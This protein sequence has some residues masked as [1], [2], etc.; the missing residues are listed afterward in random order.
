MDRVG[1]STCRAYGVAKAC[2]SPKRKG[3]WHRIDL[4][5]TP[6]RRLITV[7]VQLSMMQPAERDRK[8]VADLAP[9]RSGLGKAQVVWLGRGATAHQAGLLRHEPT[10]LLIAKANGLRDEGRRADAE[11]REAGG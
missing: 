3:D 10:V 6:P 7:P 8:L 1:A 9:E 4:E 2:A 11:A 5:T